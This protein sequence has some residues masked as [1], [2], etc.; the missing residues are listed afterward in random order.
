MREEISYGVIPLSNARG[1]WE[2]FLIQHRGGKYWGFP[3]GHAEAEESPEEAAIRELKEETNLDCL[4]CFRKEP[5]M[6]QYF[7]F[8]EG[9]RVFKKVYYFIAEVTGEFKPQ[10][11]EI[12]DGVWLPISAAIDKVTH[13]EGKSILAE[14]VKILSH[15]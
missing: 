10:V 4:R 9:K 5:L 14:V 8:V 2:V 6:E 11:A 12:K 3:K 15:S 7:F 13:P 1:E